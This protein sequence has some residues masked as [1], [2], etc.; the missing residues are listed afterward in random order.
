MATRLGR[1][2]QR[3]TT[4]GFASSWADLDEGF[5]WAVDRSLR[6]VQEDAPVP[7]YWAGLTDRPMFYSRDLAH[8]ALAGH[9]LGLDA[10]NRAMLRCFAESATERRRYYPLW[11]FLF[12]GSPAEIDYR[13]DD[14]F[15]RETP[16]PFELVETLHTLSRW[17][18]DHTYLSDDVF[19]RFIHDVACRFVPLHDVLGLGVAGEQGTE[20]IFSGSPTYNEGSRAPGL[21]VA[22]DGIASQWAAMA[23]I[24]AQNPDPELA[25]FARAEA[26]RLRDLFEA[27]WYDPA[28]GRY[29][30]GF[31]R[32][33]AIADF[34]YEPSWF[35]AVK[36]LIADAQ[37]ADAHLEYVS[38]QLATIPPHNIEAF[39][40]LPEAFL[41]YGHDDAGL[42]WIRHLLGSRADYPEVPFTLVSHLTVG[43]PGVRLLA[44]DALA[45]RSHVDDGW[46]EASGIPWADGS[47]SVRHDGGEKTDVRND[48]SVP[49]RWRA[50]FAS[51]AQETVLAPGE[52]AELT[53]PTTSP[54]P[55]TRP[56]GN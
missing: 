53:A 4:L 8:Q 46:I 42:H 22:G 12:D 3:E 38:E 44:D 32:G 14:D 11:S 34:A 31:G 18:G 23:A 13:S 16:A 27:A 33:G 47:V 40:Y 45:T 41:R 51:G 7:S 2:T 10:E 6:W 9:L 37:R 1:S 43:L 30:T 39:T 24:A 25:D 15:V 17:T 52:H 5:A 50:E 26:T 49:V 54:V 19:R 29:V 48:R 36:G 28:L 56:R 20:D 21:Q 35:P 55:L